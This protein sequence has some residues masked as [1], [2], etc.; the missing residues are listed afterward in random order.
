MAVGFRKERPC[1][2]DPAGPENPFGN[3]FY[4]QR[5]TF[6]AEGQAKRRVN[7]DAARTWLVESSNTKNALGGRPAP[8]LVPRENCLPFA[9]PGSATTGAPVICGITSG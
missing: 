1:V 3:A 4:P 7:T 6:D 2:A 9:Q 5:T 8:K